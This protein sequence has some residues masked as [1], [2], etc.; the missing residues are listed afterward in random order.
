M[1]ISAVLILAVLSL[2]FAGIALFTRNEPVDV[3]TDRKKENADDLAALKVVSGLVKT[4]YHAGELIWLSQQLYNLGDNPLTVWGA[5]KFL[6][7]RVYDEGNL[8]MTSNIPGPGLVS[9]VKLNLYPGEL[10]LGG[11]WTENYTFSLDQPGRYKIV[12][13]AEFSKDVNLAEPLQIYAEP[14][15]IEIVT[16]REVEFRPVELEKGAAIPEEV[17]SWVENSMKFDVAYF[18]NAQEFGGKQYLFV[19]SGT[20]GFEP[21]ER[22]VE[23][24]DVLV[25]EEEVA[26]RV[27][28][29]KPSPGQQIALEDLYDVV[30]IEAT[31]LP[32]R[33][34]PIAH[35]EIF[36]RSLAGIHY[37]PD[38]VAQSRSIKVFA[39]APGEV[40]GRKF[41]VSGVDN[42]KEVHYVLRD[43]DQNVL[44]SGLGMGARAPGFTRDPVIIEEHLRGSSYWMYFTFDIQ[45]PEHVADGAD[46]ILSLFWSSPREGD[47]PDF[48]D[49][50]LKF[51]SD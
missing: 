30:Y 14:V 46:L 4:H 3:A 15:W 38:I 35:E 39:P 26:V 2:V 29:S 1:L 8:V 50:P 12:A 51:K 49:I 28:F 6:F 9:P 7:F 47:K 27:S 18:V 37:L 23:I 21:F 33:F 43:A 44:D 17:R 31:G 48:V 24:I 36:F 34:V 25:M 10:D 5:D 45:V 22:L 32:V 19:R 13:W 40:V 41:S 16:G 20:G 11:W 42:L